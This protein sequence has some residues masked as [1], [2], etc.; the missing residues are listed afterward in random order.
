[1]AQIV[2]HMTSSTA[3]ETERMLSLNATHQ[4]SGALDV[5]AEVSG[6]R[7][8]HVPCRGCKQPGQSGAESDRL[9]GCGGARADHYQSVTS[10]GSLSASIQGDDAAFRRL[11]RSSSNISLSLHVYK[12]RWYVLI[13]YSLMAFMQ[14][15][16]L[17]VWSVIAKSVEVAFDWTD[18][19]ISLMQN[20][21]YLSY[22]VSMFPFAWLMFK[23]GNSVQ[24]SCLP[25]R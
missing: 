25:T 2:S 3:E 15:G 23:K 8:I 10:Y 9:T 11:H 12:R 20:W 22:L 17:N 1:M 19:E 5:D 21:I 13:I 4:L 24:H 14:G 18:S 16:L 6:A 7:D